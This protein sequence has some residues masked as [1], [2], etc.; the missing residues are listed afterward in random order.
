MKIVIV[1]PPRFQD[2]SVTREGRCEF[3]CNYRVDTP[4][5]LLIIASLLSNQKYQIDF[6]DANAKDLD[7]RIIGNLLKNKYPDCVI[8]TFNSW[9]IDHDLIICKIAKEINP[10]CKT[11]GYSWFA[12]NFSIEIL[13]KFKNL[14][15]QIIE[16][17]FSVIESLMD[18]LNNRGN[19]EKIEGIAYKNSD[20]EIKINNKLKIK[21]SFEE[22]PFPA[23]NLIESF[24]PYYLYTPFLKPYAL[25]YAG[26]GC[27]YSCAYCPDANTKYSGRSAEDIV[28]ELKVLKNLG[29]IKYVWFYDQ[30]FTINRKR[31][32]NFC[33][34]MIEENLNISWFCDTR[35]DLVD[36]RLLKLMKTAG[37]IGVAYGIESGSQKILDN[38][39]KSI[40]II[41]AI[42][43][44]KWTRKAKI[45]IQLNLILG[46]V[47]ED[48]N[49]LK[50]TGNFIR[51]ILPE[52]LQISFIIAM[53]G[54][55]FTHLAIK[56]DWISNELGSKDKFTDLPLD[57]NRY[58]PF[59]LNLQK[60][61]RKLFKAIF[62]NLRWWTICIK[63]LINNRQLII[64]ILG[65]LLYR[66][67]SIK[68]L[69]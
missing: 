59:Q 31:V 43:A 19:L 3:I 27:P 20:N 13:S 47:G 40:S 54:T 33:K 30:V 41:Q 2:S 58:K 44:L 32:I 29:K 64:P 65:M 35:A 8:F 57:K 14:D 60:E 48:I 12:K 69:K 28:E 61:I 10:V 67:K 34:K 51:L 53:S 17:P 63:S 22:L 11:I 4:A 7:Y 39:K 68:I 23:Y 15:I 49:T 5:T 25:V 9:I 55:E 37:C 36:E 42:R 62:L 52:F 16:D 46:Y 56:N 6:I 21:K 24:K 50:E 1:N 26:K 38:M 45:P 18:C 66:S